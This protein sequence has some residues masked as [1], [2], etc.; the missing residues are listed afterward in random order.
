MSKDEICELIQRLYYKE[1]SKKRTKKKKKCSRI[2]NIR[3]KIALAFAK[4]YKE[5]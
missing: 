1:S 3:D 5:I 4:K 2:D